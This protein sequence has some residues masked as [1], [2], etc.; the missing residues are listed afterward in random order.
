MK[1]IRFSLLIIGI[2][3]F[4]FVGCSKD[5]QDWK[6]AKKINSIE[7]YQNFIQEY[8]ESKFTGSAKSK[9]DSIA[10]ENVIQEN[11]EEAY[12]SYYVEYPNSKF[13]NESRNKA[14][15]IA[16]ENTKKRKRRIGLFRIH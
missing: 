9:I 14:A 8:P 3:L 1:L 12:L 2:A 16:F 10:Y 7:S 13:A 11:T 5:K 4:L 15:L 6:N